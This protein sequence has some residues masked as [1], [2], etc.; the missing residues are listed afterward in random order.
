MFLL[1]CGWGHESVDTTQMYIDAN[2]KLKEKILEKT[3]VQASPV[4]R[5]RPDDQL[6]AFLNSL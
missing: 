3:S 4:V 1:L 5:Y 2:L 6:L